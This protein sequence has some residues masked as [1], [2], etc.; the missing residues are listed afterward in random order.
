MNS[1]LD[2]SAIDAIAVSAPS[3]TSFFPCCSSTSSFMMSESR[4]GGSSSSSTLSA[5][6]TVAAQACACTRGLLKSSMSAM[7]AG[8]SFAWCAVCSSGPRSVH[9]WPSAWHAA[10]RTLGWLSCSPDRHMSV[11][12][13]SCFCISL[14]QPS[15]ICARQMSVAWRRRQ[16]ASRS[17]VGSSCPAAGTI[18]LPPSDME[19]RS[20]HSWPNWKRSPAPAS[21]CWSVS[22]LCH[23]GS[24]S[25]SIR[26]VMS[27]SNRLGTKLGSLRII[28]GAFSRASHSVTRNSAAS[29]RV[30]SSSCSARA[31][32]ST[33]C[34]TSTSC[35]R[36]KRGCASATSIRTSSPS[37][38]A[39]SS[40]RLRLPPMHASIP[41]IMWLN[42]SR[43]DGSSSAWMK[44]EMARSD[45]SCT[46]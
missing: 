10:H 28:P 44:F 26:N 23:S 37:C 41:G 31:I 29:W 40:P 9:I 34:T 38:A 17:H 30:A 25:T 5:K 1:A 6:L 13:P 27:I 18:A 20:R 12:G 36:R 39:S 43:S 3:C 16:S 22:A 11:S 45:A 15:A 35:L 21:S 8:S 24:S 19:M 4:Y 32:W 46:S 14:A 7:S 2:E 33:A 42:L